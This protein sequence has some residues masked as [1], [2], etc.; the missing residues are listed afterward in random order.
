MVRSILYYILHLNQLLEVTAYLLP[1]GES[2]E[3]NKIVEIQQT[4]TALAGLSVLVLSR[5]PDDEDFEQFWESVLMAAR[6]K[7]VSKLPADFSI[8]KQPRKSLNYDVIVTDRTCPEDLLVK[9]KNLDLPVV[10]CEWIIQ[11]LINGKRMA[12]NGHP[13]YR[14]DFLIDT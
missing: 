3:D 11:C 6:C 4:H 13:K 8:A 1:A 12:Y 10:S 14:H 5:N 7:K 2:I 9:A